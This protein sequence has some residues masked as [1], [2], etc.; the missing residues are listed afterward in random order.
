MTVSWIC[1]KLGYKNCSIIKIGGVPPNLGG[2]K[3]SVIPRSYSPILRAYSVSVVQIGCRL[4]SGGG[5][6]MVGSHP[7]PLPWVTVVPLTLP[8]ALA[9]PL[10]CKD[11]KVCSSGGGDSSSSSSSLIFRLVHIWEGCLRCAECLTVRECIEGIVCM[12]HK[13]LISDSDTCCW[14]SEKFACLLIFQGSS[15]QVSRPAL[16]PTPDHLLL[17]FQKMWY[18]TLLLIF[19]TLVWPN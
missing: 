2:D 16:N 6:W 4:M 1:S 10:S 12:Q 18:L 7:R 3:A 5:I 17:K 15:K 14:S 8:L 9:L 19:W 11:F 13:V